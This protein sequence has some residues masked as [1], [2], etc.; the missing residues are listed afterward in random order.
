M[1][2]RVIAAAVILVPA[3]SVAA[4]DRREVQ[5]NDPPPK[6]AAGPAQHKLKVISPVPEKCP[7]LASQAAR[8]RGEAVTPDKLTDLPRGKAFHAVYR[9]GRDG[10]LDPVMV[11]YQYRRDR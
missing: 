11:G 4:D 9:V 2:F 5:P 6:M 10:C 1:R 3:T 8:K 7:T